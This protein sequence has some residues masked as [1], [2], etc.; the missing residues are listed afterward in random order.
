MEVV[1][2]ITLLFLLLL[3]SLPIFMCLGLSTLLVLAFGTDIPPMIVA[4]RFFAGIDKF[5]LMAMPLFILAASA[6]DAGGLSKRILNW[7]R[8]LVGH[9]TGGLAMTTQ[10]A[11]MSFGALCGSSPATVAAIGKSMYPELVRN[12]YSKR[13]SSGLI[14]ASGSVALL[15]PPSLTMIIYATTVGVSV[16]ELFM[17]GIGAGLLYG[18][19]YLIL[20]YYYARRNKIPRSPRAPLAEVWSE[21]RKSIWSLAVPVI[22][23]GGIYSGMFTP[24]EAA[25]IA[26]GYAI[27]VG[28]FVYK[29]LNLRKLYEV[30]VDSSIASAQVLILVAS[31]T[32]FG[33]ILTVLQVP[34]SIA[35]LLLSHVS[36][37]WMFLLPLNIILLITG[38]FMD[39]ASAITILAPLIF[40]TAIGFN[41]DPV[42]LG[43]V[44][45]ANLT[46]G[47]FTP[48]F[49]LN[50]FVASAITRLSLRELVPGLIAFILISI[51]ALMILTYIPQISLALPRLVYR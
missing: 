4:Q 20:I 16:G 27:F 29:E 6:M 19:L 2:L 45:V 8:V 48:P 17:A 49:G 14:T 32:A 5:A 22:I 9:V 26:A 24:T 31:A 7:S 10:F 11:C 50:I 39:G 44:M 40:A 28:M 35:G 51:A 42:H 21:T 46:I 36:T 43:V 47:N 1:V 25:G 12:G 33:W 34:Q 18:A 13:F 41:I 3:G 23:L 15:I 30:A 38:M 37:G